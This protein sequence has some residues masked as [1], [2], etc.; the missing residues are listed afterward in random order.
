MQ[1]KIQ[2]IEP[3]AYKGKV[4][5]IEV[6]NDNSYITKYFIVHNCSPS[7]S[8]DVFFDRKFLEKMRPIQPIKISSDF[9]IFYKFD[10]S[11]RYGGGFDVSGGVGLDSSTSCF[12]DFSTVPFRVV[13][14]YK[15]NTIKPDI[16]GDEIFRQAEMFGEPL[17]NPENNNHGHATIGRLKQLYSNIFTMEQLT[18]TSEITPTKSR[19]YGWNTNR[20]TKPKMLFDLKKMVES[21]HLELSD[22]D[23]IEEMK[24]FTR[25]DLMDGTSDVRL[26]T[27]HFDLLF[28]CGL[29]AQMVNYTAVA[30]EDEN[31]STEM[32]PESMEVY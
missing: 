26:A 7:I 16:F 14:T 2:K 25:D 24:E 17:L 30:N 31:Y 11:H 10:P 27:R 18:D 13:A 21:G 22:K 1:N 19:T 20:L 32:S 9:K 15:S 29:A 6:E 23:L 4:H 5:N 12:I 3:S 28:A 8:S